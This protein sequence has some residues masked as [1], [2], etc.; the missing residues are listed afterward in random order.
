[1]V[2]MRVPFRRG[3]NTLSPGGV[4]PV[5]QARERGRTKFVNIGVA[6]RFVESW[7][8]DIG[9]REGTE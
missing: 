9:R 5:K 1:V 6:L 3:A 7:M 2:G 8:V 4:P